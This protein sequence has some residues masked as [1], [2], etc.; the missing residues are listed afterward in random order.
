MA[1]EASSALAL[2]QLAFMLLSQD[3]ANRAAVLYRALA[4]MQP[5]QAAHWRGLALAQS[6]AGKPA[7]ALAALDQLALR[8][9]VDAPFYLLRARVLVDLGRLQEAQSVMKAFVERLQGR[10]A[11][12]AVKGNQA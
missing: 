5:D 1:L 4:L 9:Q 6:R 10:T 7:D 11:A 12:P 8:G 3:Y 2:S